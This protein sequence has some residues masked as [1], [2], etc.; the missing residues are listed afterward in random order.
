[1][2]IIS[3]SIMTHYIKKFD[4]STAEIGFDVIFVSPKNSKAQLTFPKSKCVYHL[5]LWLEDN[6]IMDIYW[7]YFILCLYLFIYYIILNNYIYQ[8]YFFFVMNEIKNIIFYFIFLTIFTCS[9]M[10]CHSLSNVMLII[11]VIMH[12]LYPFYLSRIEMLNYALFF[13]LILWIELIGK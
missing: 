6:L 5:F 11:C 3:L 2:F 13:C 9:I 10:H 8:L 4:F 1:M 12:F 7:N